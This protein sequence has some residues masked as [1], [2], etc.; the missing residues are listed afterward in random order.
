MQHPASRSPLILAPIAGCLL[1][2]APELPA[3]VTYHD[4]AGNTV[5]AEDVEVEKLGSGMRFVEGPIWLANEKRLLFSDI[6]RSKILQWSEEGGI[7]EFRESEQSNGNT[8]DRQGRLISCQHAGRNV[9]RTAADGSIT[10]LTETHDGKKLN[11]PNDA[12]V[13]NDGTIW[14]TDPTYGLRGREKEQDGNYVYCLDPETGASRIV[15]EDFD[16]PNGICFSPGHDRVYIADSGK[17]Q[18][19]GAFEIADDG[20]L[21]NLFWLEGGA[22]G[23]RCDRAGNL[24]TTARDGI[25]AYS[26]KG[27]HLCTIAIPEVPANCAFGGEDFTTLFVTA[28]TSLYRL[29]LLIPGAPVPPKAKKAAPKKQKSSKG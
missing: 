5:V 2:L 25:R 8:L 7:T 4:A 22:D 26:P 10:V 6:P 12:A 18:R 29:Q 9:V 27:Q 19:V 14:F 17:K 13:R 3:Q 21:K 11:S 1:W 28:R 23:I 15:S 20:S 24:Y 16:M